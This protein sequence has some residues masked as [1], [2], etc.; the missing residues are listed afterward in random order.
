MMRR[1][2]LDHT[3][4]PARIVLPVPFSMPRNLH[5]IVFYDLH[6]S[7]YRGTWLWHGV[8]VIV[9]EIAVILGWREVPYLYLDDIK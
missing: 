8:N 1:S 3:F 7:L 9:D 4:A 5:H 6:S 2:I